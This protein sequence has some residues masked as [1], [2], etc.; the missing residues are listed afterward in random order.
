MT[1]HYLSKTKVCFKCGKEK[2]IYDFYR[3]PKMP[4]GHLN[5]CKE[6]AKK[7]VSANYFAKSNNEDWL[8]KERQRG[9]EKYH[10]LNY[11]GKYPAPRYNNSVYKQ[12][13][14]K[15][16]TLGYYLQ[17]MELHHWNY[18]NMY[19]V[20]SLTRKQHR[21]IHKYLKLSRESQ[22]FIDTRSGA[23]LDSKEKHL[24]YMQDVIQEYKEEL[25]FQDVEL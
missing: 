1:Q 12:L 10:R 11:K 24:K 2:P 5:K 8:Y 18:D 13:H 3:H 21:R 20:F 16:L 17:G 14:H 4:D 7:D 9:R 25:I 6:C 23:E 19:S 15:A 22:M